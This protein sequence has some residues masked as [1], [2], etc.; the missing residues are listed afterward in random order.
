MNIIL[1][2]IRNES[3]MKDLKDI[4]D[5]KDLIKKYNYIMNIYK[6]LTYE[7]KTEE[8]ENGDKY[9]GEFKNNKREGNGIMYYDKNNKELRLT[10]E[11]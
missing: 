3:I 5:E 1:T 10:Y 2:K 11:G 7:D 8:Y 6:N 9:I 4:N